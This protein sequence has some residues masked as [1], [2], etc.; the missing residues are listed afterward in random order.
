M[1]FARKLVL[2]EM[3]IIYS[4]QFFVFSQ[5]GPECNCVNG[6][7]CTLTSAGAVCQCLDNIYFPVYQ[8][9][10]CEYSCKFCFCRLVK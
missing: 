2:N 1:H 9:L 7:T 4:H 10:Y 3:F 6:G 5:D 8:G